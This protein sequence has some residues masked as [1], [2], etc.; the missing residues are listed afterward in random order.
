MVRVVIT[1]VKEICCTKA[2]PEDL[3]LECLH[4]T[5]QWYHAAMNKTGAIFF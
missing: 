1:T 4:L 2:V 5:L 3:S